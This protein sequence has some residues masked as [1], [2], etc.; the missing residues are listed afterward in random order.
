MTSHH[1]PPFRLERWFAEFE[2][3]PGMRNLAASAPFAGTTRELLELEDAE[4]TAG[5]LDLGL[6]YTENPGSES[7]RQGIANLYATLRA[8][9]VQVT[10]GLKSR[11]EVLQQRLQ[12]LLR[13]D[14]QSNADEEV[15]P[16]DS[17]SF[18]H[19]EVSHKHHLV[20]NKAKAKNKMAKQSR[21]K[22][23]RKK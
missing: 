12:Y 4:T 18:V 17:S 21:K 1:F 6:D 5:Y 15:A 20:R 10:L 22:N 23:R 2:F 9:D 7:L 14:V 19:T 16:S 3:V 11:E 13:A 8:E